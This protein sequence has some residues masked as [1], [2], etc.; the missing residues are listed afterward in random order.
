MPA[1]ILTRFIVKAHDLIEENYYW[2]DGVVLTYQGTTR[3]E[4]IGDEIQKRVSI[5]ISGELRKEVIG[6]YPQTYYGNSR[7][8]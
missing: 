8:I 7:T 2:K 3:A 5:R 6:N 4:I 1:G